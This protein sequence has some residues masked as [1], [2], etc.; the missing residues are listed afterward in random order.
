MALRTVYF[1]LNSWGV[2][3]NQLSL[4][5]FNQFL[6]VMKYLYMYRALPDYYCIQSCNRLINLPCLR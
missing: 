5:S 2:T 3:F 4:L 1:S 6:T